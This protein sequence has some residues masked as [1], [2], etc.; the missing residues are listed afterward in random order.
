VNADPIPALKI[1]ADPI[2]ALKINADPWGSGSRSRLYVKKKFKDKL[3]I[4]S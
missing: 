3:N 4:K 2:P 1:N